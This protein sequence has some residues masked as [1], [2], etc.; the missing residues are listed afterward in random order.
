[1]DD[2]RELRNEGT[3]I[4]EAWKATRFSVSQLEMREKTEV[5]C[6]SASS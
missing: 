2:L 6:A 4:L 1:M 3:L 5:R